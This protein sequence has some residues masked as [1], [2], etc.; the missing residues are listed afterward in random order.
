M[1]VCVWRNKVVCC[2]ESL[3]ESSKGGRKERGGRKE[4]RQKSERAEGSGGGAEKCLTRKAV[5]RGVQLE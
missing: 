3:K 2:K 5:G 1:C 4:C